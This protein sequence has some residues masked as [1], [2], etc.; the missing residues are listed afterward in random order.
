NRAFVARQFRQVN[1]VPLA[2][3]S[4]KD[5]LGAVDMHRYSGEDVRIL[6]LTR[7]PRGSTWSKIKYTKDHPERAQHIDDAARLWSRM[8]LRYI[9]LLKNI[10]PEDLLHVP[11][12]SLCHD[13]ETTVRRVEA[14]LGLPHDENILKPDPQQTHMVAGNKIRFSLQ[15]FVIREDTAWR[16]NLTDAEAQRIMAITEPVASQLGYFPDSAEMTDFGSDTA[17][18]RQ[19]NNRRASG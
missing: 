15:R 4:S 5:V 2:V 12:E 19:D 10:P 1:N 6:F 11:Y 17:S 8:N 3:D 13:P 9:R 16:K 7:D 14:F 18:A